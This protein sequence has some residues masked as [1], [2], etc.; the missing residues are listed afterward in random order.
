MLTPYRH[1]EGIF[2]KI[3]PEN[4]VHA[5]VIHGKYMPEKWEGG[6]AKSIFEMPCENCAKACLESGK[7]AVQKCWDAG[8]KIEMAWCENCARK[9][10]ACRGNPWEI[11]ARKVGRRL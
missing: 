8:L 11:H 1:C 10:D 5:V 7:E 4:G 2:A 9:W 6:C 3:V